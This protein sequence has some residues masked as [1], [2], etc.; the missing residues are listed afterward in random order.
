MSVPLRHPSD[1]SSVF[2][3]FERGI[4]LCIAHTRYTHACG[5][6]V[7]PPAERSALYHLQIL[8][9]GRVRVKIRTLSLTQQILTLT[10]IND[11]D[12]NEDDDDDDDVNDDEDEQHKRVVRYCQ[13]S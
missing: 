7:L 8:Q 11:N 4:Y 5:V 6:W 9:N 3:S 10:I 12:C 1:K 2:T 13:G